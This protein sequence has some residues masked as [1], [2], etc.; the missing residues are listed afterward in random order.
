M[1]RILIAFSMVFAAF[2]VSAQQ[3]ILSS[4]WKVVGDWHIA[5]DRRSGNN[6]F[7]VFRQADGT[8]VRVGVS[9]GT[10]GLYYFVKKPRWASIKHGKA[11]N[12]TIKFDSRPVWHVRAVGFKISQFDPNEVAWLAWRYETNDFETEFR[13]RNE[14][15][16]FY[17]TEEVARVPL[18]GSSKAL[19]ELRLCQ[20]E[21]RRDG[22]PDDDPFAE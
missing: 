10:N 5:V 3:N 4:S 19:S 14:M 17:N 2:S 8:V 21:V 18:K 9:P 13:R 20:K 22:V 1:L 7:L 6:C 12:I 15:R 11:Y 16:I